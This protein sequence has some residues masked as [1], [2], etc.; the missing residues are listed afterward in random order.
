MQRGLKHIA[1]LLTERAHRHDMSKF[2]EDEFEGFSYFGKI[3]SS[4]PY[5]S[6]EYAEAVKEIIPFA[7]KAIMRHQQR[8]SHHPEFHDSVH[9]I[10]WLDII[11]MVTD[12]YAS[13]HTYNDNGDFDKSIE[14]GLSRWEFTEPQIWLIHQV[15][16]TLKKSGISDHP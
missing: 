10:N 8:N 14:I 9:D 5:G 11:E 16:D 3:D 13:C 7:S 12:W 15:A 1:H 6:T 2:K 4:V